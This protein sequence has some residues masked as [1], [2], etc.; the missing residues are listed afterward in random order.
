MCD[1]WKSHTL[2]YSDKQREH[3]STFY[4][5]YHPGKSRT[6]N[7]VLEKKSFFISTHNQLTFF[8]KHLREGPPEDHPTLIGARRRIFFFSILLPKMKDFD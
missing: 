2:R 4:R 7:M 3:G 5:F 1:S 6:L 8:M